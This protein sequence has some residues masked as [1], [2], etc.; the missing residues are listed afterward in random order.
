MLKTGTR[1]LV[2]VGDEQLEGTVGNITPM[3]ENKKFSL[4]CI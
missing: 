1:V 3:V 4:M 2:N